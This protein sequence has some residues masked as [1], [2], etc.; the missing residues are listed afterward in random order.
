MSQ[1]SS[2]A[3]V[4]A[5]KQRA[6]DKGRPRNSKNTKKR[7]HILF[8]PKQ[9]A[10]HGWENEEQPWTKRTC[11]KY[12]AWCHIDKVFP[13]SVHK[14]HCKFQVANLHYCKDPD[15][16]ER[17]IQVHQHLYDTAF[18]KRNEGSLAILRMVYAEEKLHRQVDWQTMRT[19]SQQ[20][21]KAREGIDIPRERKYKGIGGLSKAKFEDKLVSDAGVKWS[22]DSDVDEKSGCTK[23]E[24]DE[25]MSNFRDLAAYEHLVNELFPEDTLHGFE[26]DVTETWQDTTMAGPSTYATQS[27]DEQASNL[28]ILNPMEAIWIGNNLEGQSDMPHTEVLPTVHQETQMSNEE[29]SSLLKRIAELERENV[30]LREEREVFKREIQN[31]KETYEKKVEDLQHALSQFNA[32]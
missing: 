5:E 17:C 6:R 16:L 14:K 2:E 26:V 3:N 23:E 15:F 18:V 32:G 12:I 1:V 19:S 11:E 29:T 10:F 8:D 24:R 7:L 9:L 22:S 4:V 27:M 21:L 20:V 13:H 31:L 30:E 25:Q 28:P